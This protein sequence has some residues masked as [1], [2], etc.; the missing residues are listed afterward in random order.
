MLHCQWWATQEIHLCSLPVQLNS[1]SSW[2]YW[3]PCAC[4]YASHHSASW[5][6]LPI[7]GKSCIYAQRTEFSNT[8][9]QMPECP[10]L[11]LWEENNIQRTTLR[12]QLRICNA[13]C[14]HSMGKEK[15]A[16][17]REEVEWLGKSGGQEAELAS[18][19]TFTLSSWFF[20][21]NWCLFY[22][23]CDRNVNTAVLQCSSTGRVV[24]NNILKG[25]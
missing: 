17:E 3:T 14:K 6:H 20:W 16:T 25:M 8:V 10:A 22:Q 4:W 9:K 13:G 7:Y 2:Y 1:L 5:L 11:S 12:V 21:E 24:L 18:P 15:Q 19:P 23:G